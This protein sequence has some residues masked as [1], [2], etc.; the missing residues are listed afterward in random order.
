MLPLVPAYVVDARLS[1]QVFTGLAA[2]TTSSPTLPAP[3]STGEFRLPGSAVAGS[4]Y[5]EDSPL[6]TGK[7]THSLPDHCLDVA[8]MSPVSPPQSHRNLWTSLHARCNI[9]RV[10]RPL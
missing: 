9:D 8:G 2:Q 10:H 5:I 3:P 7:V 4:S 1:S 6:I